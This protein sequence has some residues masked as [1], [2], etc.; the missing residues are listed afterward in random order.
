[1]KQTIDSVGISPNG[2]AKTPLAEIDPEVSLNKD[3]FE[4]LLSKIDSGL[5]ALP[6]TAQVCLPPLSCPSQFI[7]HHSLCVGKSM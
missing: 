4:E 7:H 6:A 1:M 2:R 3:S 5:R